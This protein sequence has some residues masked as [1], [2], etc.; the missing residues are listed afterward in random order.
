MKEI[1]SVRFNGVFVLTSILRTTT[2]RYH[3][4][5]HP[6]NVPFGMNAM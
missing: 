4:F 2:Y 1:F 5:L 3:K 6:V